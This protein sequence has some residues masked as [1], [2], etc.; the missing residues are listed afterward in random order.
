ML[1]W[2]W[3]ETRLQLSYKNKRRHRFPRSLSP[4]NGILSTRS[5]MNLLK[6][7]ADFSYVS[8]RERSE[9][10]AQTGILSC[11]LD[12]KQAASSS[13][14]ANTTFASTITSQGNV[15]RGSTDPFLQETFCSYF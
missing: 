14:V 11:S 12:S 13:H 5:V 4:G 8:H 2:I 10:T 7:T 9:F 1:G 3:K 6:Q 15:R